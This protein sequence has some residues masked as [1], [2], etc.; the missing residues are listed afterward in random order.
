MVEP[1]RPP[2]IHAFVLCWPKWEK[3]AR[4]IA[5]ELHGRVDHLTVLYKNDTGQPEGGAGEWR[6]IPSDRFYG[7]QFRHTI[8]LNRGGVMLHVQADARCADW[9]ALA[10]R[11]RGAFAARPDLG[12]WTPDVYHSWYTPRITWAGRL[13]DDGTLPVTT[14]DGVVWALSAT[15]LPPLARLDWSVNNLGWGVTEAAAAVA[16]TMDRTVVMDR[17]V[18]VEHPWGSGYNRAEALRQSLAFRRQLSPAQQAYFETLTALAHARDGR[19]VAR[20]VKRSVW[21]ETLRGW[22]QRWARPPYADMEDVWYASPDGSAPQGLWYAS[23]PPDAT[24]P[25]A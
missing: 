15:V 23:P 14:T 18:K 17:T 8:D 21:K 7:W 20:I 5:R 2:S 22:R 3:A 16:V 13:D 10:A 1:E 25:D 19:R 11:C 12:V 24:P 9:P 6:R 4:H